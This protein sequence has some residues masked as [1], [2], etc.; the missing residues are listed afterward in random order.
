MQTFI[1]QRKDKVMR[2]CFISHSSKKGGAERA[3][4]ELIDAL[5]A[6]EV[7]AYVLLPSCGPLIEELKSR[8]IVYH[9]FHYKRWMSKNSLI[10]KRIKRSVLNF[11]MAI[12]VA[13]RLKIWRCDVVYTNTITVCVGALAARLLKLPHL[14][15]IHEF[16]YEDHGLVFN[17]GQKA[18]LW[19]V[20]HLSTI[21]VVNS[22]A[23]AKKY[24]QYIKPSKLRV[25]YYSVGIPHDVASDKAV[26]TT[27]VGIR[28][29]IVGA[30]QEGKRQEDAIRAIAELVHSG[31]KAQLLI[32]GE[33]NRK[34]RQY[35]QDLVA[36]IDLNNYV[37]FVGY[38]E[39]PFPLMQSADVVLMCSI[40]E[41]FGRVTVEAMKLGTPVIGARSGGT[42][43]LI[44]E[45]FNG[46]LYTHGDYRELA[47]KIK[48]FYE[49]PDAAQMMGENARRWVTE[50]FTEDRYAE[51]ILTALRQL[52][53]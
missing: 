28:C 25:V 27:N 52:V 2:V 1:A 35:L 45:G 5:R 18:S 34:Y 7:E 4:L 17:L 36:N 53:R 20:D 6:R 15:H 47:E 13:V 10:W 42:I 22:H 33:G 48:Y 29:V 31:I 41:A 43:E 12:P 3:L 50:Q 9:I 32:V 8:E 30:L 21:C 19:I 24:Q 11:G 51:E 14:W 26:M 44:R 38:V 39:P 46:L 16:G 23:V 40:S 37:T 49:Y